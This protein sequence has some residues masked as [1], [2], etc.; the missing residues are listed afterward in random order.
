MPVSDVDIAASLAVLERGEHVH[1]GMLKYPADLDRFRHVIQATQPDVLVETGT[2]TGASARWFADLGIDV[3][4]VDLR[5][6]D[7]QHH[8]AMQVVGDSVDPAVVT[9]VTDLVDGRR[10]MVT[11]DSNHSAA[12]VMAE[13]KAYGELVAPG[14]YLVVEDT[15]F[16]YAPSALRRRH[17]VGAGGDGTPMDAVAALQRSRK[18]RRDVAVETMSLITASPA[19]W[20]VRL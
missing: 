19:G 6:V 14:C 1:S 11:L 3:V 16:H 5:P 8:R 15:I 18:W 20:W 7:V 17:G 2:R 13:I 12:H 9:R 4:T 10:A